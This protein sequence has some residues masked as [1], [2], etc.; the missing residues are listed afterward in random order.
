MSESH[1]RGSAKPARSKNK[2]NFDR[3]N[4][5]HGVSDEIDSTSCSFRENVAGTS[6]ERSSSTETSDGS[7]GTEIPHNVY[8]SELYKCQLCGYKYLLGKY[9][10]VHKAMHKSDISSADDIFE[11]ISSVKLF[12]CVVCG[13]KKQEIE[14]LKSH[15]ER[16]HPMKT[17]D[18]VQ[19]V[20]EISRRREIGFYFHNYDS[21]DS[22]VSSKTDGLAKGIA[23]QIQHSAL[24]KA[25]VDG[26]SSVMATER[27]ER[28]KET[29]KTER[30]KVILFLTFC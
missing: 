27:T 6:T 30:T 19:K 16:A 15:I 14:G 1:F 18:K 4:I 20:S 2:Q 3:Q 7:S 24:K 17:V 25:E 22:K 21:I 8:I 5:G 13:V 28:T 10:D 12:E 26:E 11:L 9:L 23:G 29:E